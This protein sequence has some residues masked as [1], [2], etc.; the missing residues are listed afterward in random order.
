[1]AVDDAEFGIGDSLTIFYNDLKTSVTFKTG[2]FINLT[3]NFLS[4]KSSDGTEV[5]IPRDR[6]V[7]IEKID[8]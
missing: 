3:D 5:K 6:I 2:S 7:R 1:M 4:V 8:N